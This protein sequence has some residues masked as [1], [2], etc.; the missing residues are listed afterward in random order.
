M[1]T[2]LDSL[3]SR[4]VFIS[5]AN[6]TAAWGRSAGIGG[7]SGT[8][9]SGTQFLGTVVCISR[10]GCSLGGGTGGLGFSGITTIVGI[11]RGAG[12]TGAGRFG[13]C[14]SCS[15]YLGR[16]LLVLLCLGGSS[17]GLPKAIIDRRTACT[18]SLTLLTTF[19][20]LSVWLQNNES[21]CYAK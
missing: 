1:N 5:V 17:G 20:Q 10:I 9:D 4:F 18:E 3:L 15:V 2:D 6:C 7:V 21:Y 13:R 8:F 14:S 16:V 11:L 19:L 12:W